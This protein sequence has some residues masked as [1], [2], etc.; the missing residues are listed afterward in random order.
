MEYGGAHVIEDL[1]AGKDVKLYAESYGT[2]CYPRKE[3]DTYIN[4]DN[5]NQAYMFNPRNAYQNYVAAI[6]VTMPP[7]AVLVPVPPAHFSISGVT[8]S[9]YDINL[10]DLHF[11]GSPS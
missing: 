3:I 2:D 10:E 1:I 11:L 8:S 5:I 9:T 7:V 4:K 6:L